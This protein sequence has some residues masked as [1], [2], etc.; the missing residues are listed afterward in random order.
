MGKKDI[1]TKDYMKECAVFADAFNKNPV[2]L[3]KNP[4]SGEFISGFYKEDRL[5]PVITLV[6]Y[7]GP[8]EW[9]GPISLHE[10]LAVQEPE[11][12]SYISDYKLNLVAPANMTDDELN[13]F[14][15]SLREVMLFIKYSKD[16]KKL[17]E[18]L[19]KDERFRTV[20]KKAAGVISIVT[21]TEL[22][23]EE[24]EEVVD[25]CEGMRGIIEDATNEG[26]ERGLERGKLEGALNMCIRLVQQGIV[27][28]S[29]AA[30]QLGMTEE[31]LASKLQ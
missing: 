28:L 9:D 6:L 15:T 2:E 29:E 12:L 10:M 27:S 21:G 4:T 16:K 17:R 13:R 19:Q 31:E 11:I 20:D 30:K 23:I 5:I 14:T 25:M 1:I 18:M 26:L 8:G 7:F 3:E 24:E 22:E